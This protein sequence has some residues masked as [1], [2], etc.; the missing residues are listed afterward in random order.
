M[1]AVWLFIHPEA[2]P[3]LEAWLLSKGHKKV[4]P[5]GCLARYEPGKGVKT[6]VYIR[7]SEFPALRDALRSP[8]A[9]LCVA[10]PM[11][12]IEQHAGE[13]VHVP[14]GWV[15]QVENL[16]PSLKMAWDYYDGRH[17]GRY[18][19]AHRTV[20]APFFGPSQ[21]PDYMAF[22][23]AYEPVQMGLLKRE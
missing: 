12:V 15:H 1:L 13:V 7:R 5:Y 4:A 20:V 19:R 10:E 11:H 9:G 2:L 3:A 18:A 8:A 16:A 17:M 14:S 21:A 6:R 23:M 22:Y